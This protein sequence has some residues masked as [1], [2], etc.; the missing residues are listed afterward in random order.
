MDNAYFIATAWMDLAL[1]ASLV[2]TRPG[3]SVALV[4]IEAEL[5]RRSR[6]A[7]SS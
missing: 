5:V 1:V 6:Q 3:I 4:E 2:S 7:G